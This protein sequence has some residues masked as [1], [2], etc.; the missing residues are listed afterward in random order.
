MKLTQLTQGPAAPRV[1]AG[2]A[3]FQRYWASVP[4]GE[5][6]TPREIAPVVAALW[7]LTRAQNAYSE[8]AQT[9]PHPRDPQEETNR[10]NRLRY[11]VLEHPDYQR[12][13]LTYL[14]QQWETAYSAYR[15]AR[16]PIAQAYGWKFDALLPLQHIAHSGDLDAFTAMYLGGV[17][18]GIWPLMN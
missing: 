8:A 11:E 2:V 16:D 15:A 9:L 18:A 6:P 12:A 17:E 5:K 7:K 1:A 4:E 14:R 10:F 3:E 13:R